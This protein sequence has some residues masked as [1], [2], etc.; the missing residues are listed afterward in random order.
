MHR[1]TPADI[2]RIQRSSFALLMISGSQMPGKLVRPTMTSAFVA[3]VAAAGMFGR[4]DDFRVRKDR[5]ERIPLCARAG[6]AS[7]QHDLLRHAPVLATTRGRL[8]FAR[9]RAL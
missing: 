3:A 2:E 7:Q 9:S 1:S 6:V 4:H 8:G 5:G